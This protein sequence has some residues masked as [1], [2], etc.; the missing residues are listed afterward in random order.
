MCVAR[1]KQYTS[2]K[3][4]ACERHNE[5]KNESY[6]NVNV[7][8]ERIPMNVHF[9]DPGQESYMDILR[10]MEQS[11]SVSTRGLRQ[12]AKLFDEL[13]FDV[14]TLYFEEHGGYDFAVRFYEEAWKRILSLFPVQGK[15]RGLYHTDLKELTPTVVNPLTK[16]IEVH[17]SEKD[18]NG[19]KHV[20]ID[21]FFAAV[22]I[23]N[24]PTEKEL[25]ATMEEIREKPLKSA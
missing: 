8:P 11:S 6:G 16:R 9:K 5:R 25:I 7:D 3:I 15:Q 1:I 14:N 4:G 18:E 24:I 17:N 13:V 2:A 20:P 21:I 19:T 22:G 12:D 10:R 23:I